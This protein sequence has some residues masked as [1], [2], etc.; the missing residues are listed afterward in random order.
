MTIINNKTI[1]VSNFNELKDILTTENTYNYIYLDKDITIEEYFKINK[2]KVI[3]DGTYNTNK[4]TITNNLSDTT[5]NTLNESTIVFKNINITSSNNLGFIY[6]NNPSKIV[7]YNVRFN[8]VKLLY[9]QNGITKIIDSYIKI[10][11]INNISAD[12]VCECNNILIG[13][14][15]DIDSDNTPFIYLHTIDAYFKILPSSR[16]N[17]TTKNAFFN[18]TPRLDFKVSKCSEFNLV[19]GNGFAQTIGNGC[20]DVLIDEYSKFNFIE[21]SHQRVPMWNI[22]GDVTVNENASLL[23]I[24]SY[25]NTPSDNYN[26]YFKG[27]NQTIKFNNPKNIVLYTKNAN[28]L[29][30]NNIVNY[31]FTFNRINMWKDS[32]NVLTAGSIDDLPLY[33]WYKEDELSIIK[34]TFDKT[35]T[36][37]NYTNFTDEEKNKLPSLDNFI[38]QNRKEFSIGRVKIN[39]HPI[40]N[41]STKISGHTKEH[42]DVSISYDATKKIVKSDENGLFEYIVDGGIKAET[43]IKIISCTPTSY[44]YEERE[45]I[46][47]FNGEIT[48]LKSTEGVNF[49]TTYKE[50]NIYNKLKPSSITIIDSRNN[51]TNYKLYINYLN[52]LMSDS[53]KV[54]NGSL[55][56]KDENNN[57]NL[58]TTPTLVYENNKTKEE[59]SIK[60]INY[61]KDK[62]LLLKLNDNK[63][64]EN[65]YTKYIWSIGD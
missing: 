40:T 20:N 58:T 14:N 27:T 54:I 19:T 1:V 36:S 57:F 35:T 65:Y 26:I 51:N 4:Y 55:I 47:P 37:V 9:N 6:N 64:D 28:V 34:G 61:D 10:E 62:G 2:N 59:I 13:G 7:F 50:D 3:I 32:K 31:E 45:V 53:S 48:L 52:P 41:G 60:E 18:G 21:N 17:I 46:T 30:T 5:I 8:G 23:I 15:S 38:F 29:Y 11:N 12:K 49:D 22:Y 16:V 25:E 44:M 42:S 56:F 63:L 24:N 39:I 43:V 33:S